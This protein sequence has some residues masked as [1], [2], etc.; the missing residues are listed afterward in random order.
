VALLQQ[1]LV[2]A[3]FASWVVLVVLEEAGKARM[4]PERTP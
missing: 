4:R 1:E 2:G 3:Y